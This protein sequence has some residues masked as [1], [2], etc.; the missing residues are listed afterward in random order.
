MIQNSMQREINFSYEGKSYKISF[1]TVEQEI[2]IHSRRILYS[3]GA[4]KDIISE[5]TV[6]AV[7]LLDLI[8]T[9][10]FFSVLSEELVSDIKGVEDLSEIDQ[11]AI[12]PLIKAYKK[13]ILPWLSKWYDF[14]LNDDEEVDNE[15]DESES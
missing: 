5:S 10:A 13:E 4:Y 2:A 1:P 11:I 8:N 9:V 7:Y 6:R 3:R 15:K 14:L 12:K